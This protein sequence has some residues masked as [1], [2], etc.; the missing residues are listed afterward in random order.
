MKTKMTFG[1]IMIALLLLGVLPGLCATDKPVGSSD[2]PAQVGS[3]KNKVTV[4]GKADKW[5]AIKALPSVSAKKSAGAMKLAWREEGLYGFITI[6][7]AK[8]D[9]DVDN[10]W[11]K[12]CVEIWLETDFARAGTMSDNSF[13]I[14]FAPTP[15]AFDGKCVV[16][17]PQGSMD[18][19]AITAIAKKN[20]DGYTIEFF[21][22]AKE[23]KPAK[24]AK[25]TKM[26]FTYSIDDEGKAIEQFFGDKQVDAGYSTPSSWGAIAFGK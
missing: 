12:D 13:Q 21:I 8:I 23:L 15:P 6:K 7:D 9:V 2:N 5:K 20:A 24:M 4:D 18:P 22:P 25:D 10:P 1:L 11:T 14:A 26:G 19:A 17:V 16:L 3:M